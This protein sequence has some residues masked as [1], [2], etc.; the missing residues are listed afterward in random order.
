MAAG[1]DEGQTLNLIHAEVRGQGQ[2]CACV[3]MSFTAAVK[4]L[5]WTWGRYLQSNPFKQHATQQEGT[6]QAEESGAVRYEVRCP[7][8]GSLRVLHSA[9][10]VQGLFWTET[11]DAEPGICRSPLFGPPRALKEGV[12][13][14]PRGGAAVLSGPI[15]GSRG[16]RHR[17]GRSDLHWRTA[18]GAAEPTEARL[19]AVC[20]I[21]TFSFYK[22]I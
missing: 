15:K 20:Q 3:R 8:P 19:Q 4:R 7:L 22:H 10:A 16:G 1:S 17:V 18:C 14:G 5:K 13:G 6:F 2:V 11:S 12:P 21:P 9:S